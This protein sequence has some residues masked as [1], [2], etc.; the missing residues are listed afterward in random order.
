ML[1]AFR[2]L[3]PGE[4]DKLL[5]LM[6]AKAIVESW[7]GRVDERGRKRLSGFRRGFGLLFQDRKKLRRL[8][9]DRLPAE[10]PVRQRVRLASRAGWA[11]VL[12]WNG[13]YLGSNE[14]SEREHL[15]KEIRLFNAATA[16]LLTALEDLEEVSGII[17]DQLSGLPEGDGFSDL[18]GTIAKHKGLTGK[19]GRLLGAQCIGTMRTLALALRKA[20]ETPIP[21]PGPIGVRVKDA[22]SHFDLAIAHQLE[23]NL[24][25]HT[26]ARLISDLRSATGL[27]RATPEA[28]EQ[29][30]RNCGI[31]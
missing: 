6:E 15:R 10:L 1:V 14:R 27:P 25:R 9:F 31:H 5:G 7:A 11:G 23:G 16:V 17:E 22:A 20:Y 4:R 18:L 3:P 19:G 30:L 21:D 8:I 12:S 2:N 29:R 24:K 28:I 26:V 13:A